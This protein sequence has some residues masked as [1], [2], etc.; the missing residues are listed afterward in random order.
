MKHVLLLSVLIMS[1]FASAQTLTSTR[2][3][4]R[5]AVECTAYAIEWMYRKEKSSNRDLIVFSRDFD[6]EFLRK[7]KSALRKNSSLRG[8]RR[9]AAQKRFMVDVTNFLLDEQK[10][11][12]RDCV[13]LHIIADKKCSISKATDQVNYKCTQKYINKLNLA[14]LREKN[15]L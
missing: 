3:I 15:R 8:E 4:K 1:S 13:K 7:Q 2:M 6:A 14:A 10:P 11:F 9:I 12:M 5:K